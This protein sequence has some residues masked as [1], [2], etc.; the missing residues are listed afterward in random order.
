MTLSGFPRV[1]K[2]L[3]HTPHHPP[4]LFPSPPFP[5]PAPRL[6]AKKTWAKDAAAALALDCLSFRETG[7]PYGLCDNASYADVGD[8]PPIPISMPPIPPRELIAVPTA[9][10]EEAKEESQK[11]MDV[12][13][14]EAKEKEKYRSQRLVPMRV[15]RNDDQ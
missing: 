6:P 15:R 5:R 2:S 8:A 13:M 12:D 11:N 4:P 10:L 9:L 3:Q 1:R 14:E 7:E